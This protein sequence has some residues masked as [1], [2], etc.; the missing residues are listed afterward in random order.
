MIPQ[1]KV[2]KIVEAYDLLEKEPEKTE[3]LKKEYFNWAKQ[4]DFD[5]KD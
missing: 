2:K 5:K 4:F 1:E 3:N